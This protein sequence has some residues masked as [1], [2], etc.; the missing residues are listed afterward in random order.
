MLLEQTIRGISVELAQLKAADVELRNHIVEEV[1][2]LERL[3]KEAVVLI[4]FLRILWAEPGRADFF[5][6]GPC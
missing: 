6:P 3:E 2:K 4:E 5:C 1:R